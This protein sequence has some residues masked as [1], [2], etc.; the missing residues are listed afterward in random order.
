MVQAAPPD[1]PPIIGQASAIDGDTLLIEGRQVSLWGVDAPERGQ[2][3]SRADVEFDCGQEATAHLNGLVR[4]RTVTCQPRSEPN[5]AV[6]SISYGF[7]QS[8]MASEMVSAGWALVARGQRESP[9]AFGQRQ[10][11]SLRLGLW[12]GRFK[13]PWEWRPAR[14]R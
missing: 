4:N 5:V 9:Y 11:R 12:M 10:A 6:C 1:P 3:C 7:S 8:D 2:T 13:R 14:R